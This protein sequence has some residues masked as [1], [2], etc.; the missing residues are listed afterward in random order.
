MGYKSPVITLTFPELSE[1]PEGDPIRVIIRNPRLMAPGEFL[2]G[3]T[4][5]KTGPDGQPEPDED[6]ADR[7]Y[8]RMAKIVIGWR[9]YDATAPIKVDAEGNV[10]SPP[11]PLLPLP[12]TAATVAKLPMAILSRLGDELKAATNPQ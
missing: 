3:E 4:A 7:G 12:A 11:A 2:S 8:A 1:D 5:P 10:T 6:Q 9:V